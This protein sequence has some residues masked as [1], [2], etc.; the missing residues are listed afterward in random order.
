MTVTAMLK[1]RPGIPHISVPLA[2][3][4][5]INGHSAVYIADRTTIDRHVAAG[6]NRAASMPIA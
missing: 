3:L 4:T 1:L 6:R 2:A 5:E